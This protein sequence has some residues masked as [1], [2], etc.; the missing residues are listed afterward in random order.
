MVLRWGVVVSFALLIPGIVA[1]LRNGHV[2][3]RVAFEDLRA[4]PAGLGRLEARA[5]IHAGILTLLVTPVLRVVALMGEAVV[6]RERL[7]AML[8]FGILLLLVASLVLGL[9]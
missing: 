9:R 8:S 7:F 6:A 4:L 3:H 2:P 5:L 1:M